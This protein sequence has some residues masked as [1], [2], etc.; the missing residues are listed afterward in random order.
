MIGAAPCAAAQSDYQQRTKDSICPLRTQNPRV[1]VDMVRCT[2][3]PIISGLKSIL[4]S[5]TSIM[6]STRINKNI[7]LHPLP[8]RRSQ[9]LRETTRRRAQHAREQQGA[10]RVEHA[11]L[12]AEVGAVQAPRSRVRVN[13]RAPMLLRRLLGELPDG[14]HRDVEPA[15]P[16]PRERHAVV[17]VQSVVLARAANEAFGSGLE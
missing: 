11:A 14:E 3:C 7:N 8:R 10:P 15:A 9:S 13:D 17:H 6:S 2:S 4:F 1:P 16:Q 5:V 12:L